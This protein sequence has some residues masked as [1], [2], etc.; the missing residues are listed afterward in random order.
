LKERKGEKK[1]LGTTMHN[2]NVS[3]SHVCK[4]I[5][6]HRYT[7]EIS[8]YSTRLQTNIYF[9]AKFC[10]LASFDK[11]KRHGFVKMDGSKPVIWP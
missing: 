7:R 8:Y 11:A 5:M 1:K 3:L 6:T 10:Q 2:F 9:V 4:K